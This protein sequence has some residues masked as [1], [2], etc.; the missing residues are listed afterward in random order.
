VFSAGYH[1]LVLVV[2]DVLTASRFYQDV[3]GLQE[4]EPTTDTWAQLA[5]SSLDNPQWLGLTSGTLLFE[6]HSPRPKGH[7]FGPVHF[8]LQA[9]PGTVDAFLANAK[10][11]GITLYG[12][13]TWT[14][15]MQGF[16]YYFYDP[17]DNLVE[18]WFPDAAIE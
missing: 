7:R 18:Y 1:E 13:Q 10:Q 14:R 12:P 4:I 5:T 3:V 6:E 9:K 17:D 16:S 2:K 11:H 15:R 8:A